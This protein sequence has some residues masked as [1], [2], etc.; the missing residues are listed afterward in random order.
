MLELDVTREIG[1][2]PG[3]VVG[4]QALPA[5]APLHLVRGGEMSLYLLIPVLLAASVLGWVVGMWTRRRA[6]HW[7][8]QCGSTLT[9]PGCLRA[10]A[11]HLTPTRR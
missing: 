8:P 11:H 10:G 9:C 6:D 5:R 3:R 1:P 2:A 4:F 7:C